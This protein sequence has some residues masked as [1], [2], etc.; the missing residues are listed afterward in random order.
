MLKPNY[1]KAKNLIIYLEAKL[2]HW[3][4]KHRCPGN[5][6]LFKQTWKGIKNHWFKNTDAKN[7]SEAKLKL[8]QQKVILSSH[9]ESN[10]ALIGLHFFKWFKFF[11]LV[12]PLSFEV[13]KLKKWLRMAHWRNCYSFHVFIII[14]MHATNSA[15]VLT[16]LNQNQETLR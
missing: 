9:Q 16:Q 7:K 15:L 3:K 13:I 11:M 5:L 14:K 1:S 6:L 10:L 2:S 4:G 8:I 12:Q